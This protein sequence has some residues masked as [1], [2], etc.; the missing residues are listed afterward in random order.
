MSEWILKI[1]PGLIVLV[2]WVFVYWMGWTSRVRLLLRDRV[3]EP[4]R[5]RFRLWVVDPARAR[6]RRTSDAI[7]ARVTVPMAGL[8]PL[9]VDELPY[10]RNLAPRCVEQWARF[11][12]VAAGIRVCVL[13][14]FAT[15]V[16]NEKAIR[17]GLGHPAPPPADTLD[18]LG[19]IV[20]Q[21]KAFGAWVWDGVTGMPG[22]AARIWDH[23]TE[24]FGLLRTP[25]VLVLMVCA[26]PMLLRGA[27]AYLGWHP[28]GWRQKRRRARAD[29]EVRYRPVVLLMLCAVHC[30]RVYKEHEERAA[31]GQDLVGFQR[32][33]VRRVER[34]IRRAWITGS[35]RGESPRWH[36]RRDLKRHAGRVVAALRAAEARQEANAP[37]ALR[38]MATLL[39][40]IAEHYAEGR[41]AEL[42]GDEDLADIEP[43]ADRSWVRLLVA[44]VAVVGVLLLVSWAGPPDLVSGPVLALIIT[45]I[46]TLVFR[47]RIPGP[48]DLIDIFR[49][50]D[51]R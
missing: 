8:L 4:I 11:F 34:V 36:Q 18:P 49:G 40:K 24:T 17:E 35:D 39:V 25:I 41:V 50:A 6:L 46:V 33:S 43:V 48:A 16:W 45:V 10:R 30:A 51:R 14:G 1:P 19:F 29:S 3:W 37:E 13:I 44:G 27:M 47:G 32:V 26:L 9:V 20:S 31:E 28:L 7:V 12:P 2:L 42:L 21:V 5:G 15:L 22:T 23:P 38:A